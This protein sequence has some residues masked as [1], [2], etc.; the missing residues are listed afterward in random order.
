MSSF[1]YFWMPF[2]TAVDT[3]M[4]TEND[5]NFQH[6]YGSENETPFTTD[7]FH[8]SVVDGEE[9][10]SRTGP[11]AYGS[12]AG[13]HFQRSVAPGASVTFKMRLR[14]VASTHTAPLWLPLCGG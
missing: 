14:K 12:K 6:L 4:M 9:S 11:N 1:F 13:V 8:R 10:A 7:A 2:H 5:T 3:L